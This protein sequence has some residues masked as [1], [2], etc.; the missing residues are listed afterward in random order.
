MA[1]R[2][3]IAATASA[4][5]GGEF[6]C[7][8]GGRAEISL[9]RVAINLIDARIPDNA[10]KTARLTCRW[11]PAGRWAY[12]STLPVS[13]ACSNCA[14]RGSRRVFLTLGGT[15][16][17]NHIAVCVTIWR[18]GIRGPGADSCT[19]RTAM[20]WRRRIRAS[21]VWRWRRWW[22]RWHLQVTLTVEE[23]VHGDGA[24]GVLIISRA[25][26]ATP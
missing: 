1:N 10:G 23:D 15:Y 3:P 14:G 8:A 11:L 18:R 7:R 22:K 4:A 19:F 17:C 5:A 25:W 20:N 21:R 26:R 24:A 6:V 2:Q 16:N 12:F 9:E 13:A